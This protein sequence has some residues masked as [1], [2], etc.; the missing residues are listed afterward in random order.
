MIAKSA[1]RPTTAVNTT[2]AS[3]IHAIGPQKCPKN[4]STTLRPCSA[5]SFGPT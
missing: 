3:I 2:A 1:Q 5:I 4:S